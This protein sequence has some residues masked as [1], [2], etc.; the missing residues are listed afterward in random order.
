MNS[1]LNIFIV[2]EKD[3]ISLDLS[4]TCGVPRNVHLHRLQGLDNRYTK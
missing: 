4:D 1:R 2:E 3:R